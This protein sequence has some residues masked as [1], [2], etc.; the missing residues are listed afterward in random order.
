M[1]IEGNALPRT[2]TSTV[3]GTVRARPAGTHAPNAAA[4]TAKLSPESTPVAMS[5][6]AHPTAATGITIRHQRPS[7]NPTRSNVGITPTPYSAVWGR[8][9][10]RTLAGSPVSR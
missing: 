5:K 4:P 1:K 10:E 6:T 7:T 3:T 2:R 9:R 8:R